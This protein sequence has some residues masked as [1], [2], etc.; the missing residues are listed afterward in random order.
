M[1]NKIKQYFDILLLSNGGG[2]DNSFFFFFF[3]FLKKEEVHAKLPSKI[4]QILFQ[5]N[6]LHFNYVKNN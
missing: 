6:I 5:I 2:S 3:V 1:A 4:T